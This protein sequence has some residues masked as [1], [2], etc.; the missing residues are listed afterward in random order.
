MLPVSCL[1]WV[2]I[3]DMLC[4]VWFG[5]TFTSFIM[6]SMMKCANGNCPQINMN[7]FFFFFS[8]FFLCWGWGSWIWAHILQ[9]V[10]IFLHYVCTYFSVLYVLFILQLYF[11]YSGDVHCF[12]LCFNWWIDYYV[13][14]SLFWV[15][16][17]VV[18]LASIV[19][20]STPFFTIACSACKLVHKIAGQCHDQVHMQAEST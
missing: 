16:F 8:F 15:W 12:T 11:Y 18:V 5:F 13:R 4:H 19:L 14:H 20:I 2:H 10:H 7:T 9:H 3:V 1:I 6:N 17:A